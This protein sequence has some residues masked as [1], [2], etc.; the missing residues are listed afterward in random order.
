MGFDTHLPSI[1]AMIFQQDLF[2]MQIEEE[3]KKGLEAHG[4]EHIHS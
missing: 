2:A 3:G 1:Y 4:F